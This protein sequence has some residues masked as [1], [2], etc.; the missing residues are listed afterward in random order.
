MSLPYCP[1]C[2][3]PVDVTFYPGHAAKTYGPPENCYPEEP[4]DLDAP[5]KCE[6]GYVFT[7]DDLDRWLE[8]WEPFDDEPEPDREYERD[9]V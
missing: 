3:A 5:D 9:W 8:E 2:E 6:C 7:D 4:P 1:E